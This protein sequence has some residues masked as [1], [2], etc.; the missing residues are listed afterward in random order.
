MKSLQ[1]LQ[2]EAIYKYIDD[3]V[4]SLPR[5]VRRSFEEDRVRFLIDK[6]GNIALKVD[7]KLDDKKAEEVYLLVCKYFDEN[8]SPYLDP[9]VLH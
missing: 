8:P 4:E 6:D 2:H 7:P 3:V 5:R 1:E 9:I